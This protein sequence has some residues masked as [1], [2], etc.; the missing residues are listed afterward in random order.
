[1]SAN[2]G[3]GEITY[4]NSSIAEKLSITVSEEMICYWKRKS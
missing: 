3:K 2:E 1:M 4:S